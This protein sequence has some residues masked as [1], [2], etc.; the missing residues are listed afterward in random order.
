MLSSPP[1]PASFSLELDF[2]VISAGYLT[3]RAASDGQRFFGL[4]LRSKGRGVYFYYTAAGDPDRQHKVA[5]AGLDLTDGANHAVVLDITA[6]S[7]SLTVD[8]VSAGLKPLVGPVLDC[9]EPS[10]ECITH[11]GQ[12]QGGFGLTG[13]VSRALLTF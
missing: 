2:Q 10:D 1:V 13:C 8:G 9:G 6:T 3:A 7:A 4:Y 5:W 12:R 11:V